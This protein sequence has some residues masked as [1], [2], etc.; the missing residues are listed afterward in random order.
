MLGFPST[1]R[2][3]DMPA[4]SFPPVVE[5]RLEPIAPTVP[6]PKPPAGPAPREAVPFGPDAGAVEYASWFCTIR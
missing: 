3:V 6:Y 2:G 1:Q 5:R 4:D